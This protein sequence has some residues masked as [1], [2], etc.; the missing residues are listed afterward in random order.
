MSAKITPLMAQYFTIRDQ[1]PECLLFFQVG[2][3]YELFFEHAQQA[4]P[5]LSIVLTSRGTH[6][7]QPI[8]LCGVPLH[9]LNHYVDKL[10]KAGFHVAI[11]DQ[12]E[13]AK[14]GT[15]VKRG[16]TQVLTPATL[17]DTR[18]LDEKRASYLCVCVC[19]HECAALLFVEILTGAL[20]A[21]VVPEADQKVVY[22]QLCRFMPDEIILEST[23][24]GWQSWLKQQGYSVRTTR[25]QIDE[26]GLNTWLA[27]FSAQQ[28]QYIQHL[29]VLE[30]RKSVV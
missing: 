19:T 21:C 23:L 10:I 16:V 13:E 17:T 15:V 18:L 22:Q 1:Y 30:D 11:C 28:V 8:P 4:A 27:R 20:Y 9:A 3:F 12:L 6:D 2:D 26:R 5:I 14:P 25:E 29:P 7:G 24:T